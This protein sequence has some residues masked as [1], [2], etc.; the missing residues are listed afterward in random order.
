MKWADLTQRIV[1]AAHSKRIVLLNLRVP[2]TAVSLPAS[3]EASDGLVPIDLVVENGKIAN[4]QP[5]GASGL[6]GIDLKQRMVWPAA[7]DCHTHIDKGQVWPRSPNPDGSF[8]GAIEAAAAEF[9]TWQSAED[10]R[11]RCDFSLASAYAHGTALLRTHVDASPE[12]FDQRFEVMRE[13]AQDWAGRINVQLCPFTGIMMDRDWLMR[14]VA[15]AK[16]TTSRNLSFFLQKG[17]GLHDDLDRVVRCAIDHDLSLDFHADENLDP[18]S[19]CLDAVACT[20]HRHRFERPVLVGH[21][22]ALSVQ[23]E[24]SVSKTLDRVSET[25][26]GIVALPLCNMYLQ[27]RQQ[28]G[29]PRQRGIAPLREIRARGIPVAIASDNTRDAFYAYGDLDVPELF[30]DAMRMMQLNHPVDNW[31]AAV[32]GD[33]AALI[34]APEMGRLAVGASADMILFS[35]R[36][37][38]EFAARPLHDRMVLRAGQSIDTTPP[39][40]AELDRLEGMNP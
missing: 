17:P 20:L 22:C 37:W 6:D 2:A 8:V 35:A 30:R 4:I 33:A 28:H 1:R 31:P 29:S 13:V 25:S 12:T 10:L 24:S 39:E 38:S 3:Q 14:L 16:T 11:S 23:D 19:D 9:A 27:D 32:L 36:H 7:V 40:Y 21:C 18:E 15:A 34:G 26:I 5:A